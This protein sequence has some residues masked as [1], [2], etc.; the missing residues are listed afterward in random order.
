MDPTVADENQQAAIG[1]DEDQADDDDIKESVS[2]DVE[3][4]EQESG[5]EA[6]NSELI[7]QQQITAEFLRSKKNKKQLKWKEWRMDM[8]RIDDL[9]QMRQMQKELAKMRKAKDKKK[10]SS[11][12][13]PA[14]S[15]RPMSG[16]PAQ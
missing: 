5:Y 2:S 13:K 10:S 4:G 15:D 8:L 3:A 7:A 16:M 14:P 1:E 9:S 11:K 6:F 12:N